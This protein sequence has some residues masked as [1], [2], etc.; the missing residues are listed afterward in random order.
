[1]SRP[2]SRRA[3]SFSSDPSSTA[4]Q[5]VNALARVMSTAFNV[6]DLAKYK[7]P[8]PCTCI[9]GSGTVPK[10]C[11]L[12]KRLCKTRY[13][14]RQT[15]KGFYGLSARKH[16][17]SVSTDRVEFLFRPVSRA[18]LSRRSALV[19]SWRRHDQHWAVI[20]PPLIPE[21]LSTRTSPPRALTC[22]V[23]CP[24]IGSDALLA[25]AAN[26]LPN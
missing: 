12:G 6:E 19:L 15:A 4:H 13:K 20:M 16:G 14:R 3:G 23:I 9:P 5:D 21:R 1:M 10:F 17:A 7:S 18:T 2:A 26:W 11:D 25:P 24:V 8:T 22:P